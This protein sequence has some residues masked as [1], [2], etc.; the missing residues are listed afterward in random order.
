MVS[1]GCVISLGVRYMAN[2][3][4]SLVAEVYNSRLP[5][6]GLFHSKVT[7][8][9]VES[10]LLPAAKAGN[11]KLSFNVSTIVTIAQDICAGAA[12]VCPYVN[13]A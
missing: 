4:H 10:I 7:A 2:S 1:L 8:A 6:M 13:K 9:D 3:F 5:F 12:I 11:V